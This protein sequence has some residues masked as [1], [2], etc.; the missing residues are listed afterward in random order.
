MADATD[1][2]ERASL[3]ANWTVS[4]G[5]V[6]IVGS[7]DVRGNSAGADSLTRWNANTFNGD[8]YSEVVVTTGDDD[9]GGPAVR[10]QSGAV[11][12]YAWMMPT[13]DIWTM[14]EITAG[15]Y[16]VL[17]ANYS[18]AGS[19]NTGTTARLSVTGS[20]LTPSIDGGAQATRT[21]ASITGG[22]PGIGFFATTVSFESWL[23]GP[24]AAAAAS[25]IFKS[26]PM[27]HLLVR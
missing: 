2:F 22:G 11:T 18:I 1:D 3:G 25:L 17:G 14:Y 27:Q 16:A 5:A 7:S 24:I 4:L 21:D 20:T 19:T 26:N 12:C 8:H 15:S 23:G 13:T 10:H 6:T 9:G